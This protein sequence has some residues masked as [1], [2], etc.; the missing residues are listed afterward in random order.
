MWVRITDDRV[1]GTKVIVR[2]VIV[3]SRG[4]KVTVKNYLS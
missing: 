2:K 1:S 3:R 4:T